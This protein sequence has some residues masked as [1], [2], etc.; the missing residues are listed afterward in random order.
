MW[1]KRSE[2]RGKYGGTEGREPHFSGANV[3]ARVYAVHR[4]ADF[5]TA[6]HRAAQA[7]ALAGRSA[8][9]TSVYSPCHTAWSFF[10]SRSS[11]YSIAWTT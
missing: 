9:T 7:A 1:G 5:L 10:C 4:C 11:L 8:T 6:G 3:G 2:V